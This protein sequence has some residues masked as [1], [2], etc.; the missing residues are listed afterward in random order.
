[1]MSGIRVVCERVERGFIGYIL[2]LGRCIRACESGV[3]ASDV[4]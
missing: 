4:F 2:F 3:R 1:M